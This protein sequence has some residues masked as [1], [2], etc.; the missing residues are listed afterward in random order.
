LQVTGRPS[1]AGL[2]QAKRVRLHADAVQGLKDA[3]DLGRVLAP[4]AGADPDGWFS[5]QVHAHMVVEMKAKA[6]AKC[7]VEEEGQTQK[8]WREDEG[9]MEFLRTL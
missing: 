8:P 3:L 2:A 1:Q 7:K 9:L 5:R 6:L 4:A